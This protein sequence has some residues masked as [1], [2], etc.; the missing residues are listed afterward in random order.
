MRQTFSYNKYF[1]GFEYKKKGKRGENKRIKKEMIH[2]KIMGKKQ[3]FI[4]YY[5]Y[6]IKKILFK[7]KVVLTI[8]VELTFDV[9]EDNDLNYYY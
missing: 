7:D 1:R 8:F 9:E 4:L 3:F 2:T 6:N 5:K